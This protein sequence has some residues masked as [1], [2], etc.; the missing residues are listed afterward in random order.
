MVARIA[1]QFE[2]Q[3]SIAKSGDIGGDRFVFHNDPSNGR[4]DGRQ[5]FILN[6]R[7]VGALQLT[8][9]PVTNCL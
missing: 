8:A 2:D 9:T 5:A 7:D 3:H 4:C 1:C 6:G